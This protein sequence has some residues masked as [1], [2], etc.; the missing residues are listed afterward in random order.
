MKNEAL[1]GR[2]GA[3]SCGDSWNQWVLEGSKCERGESRPTRGHTKLKWKTSKKLVKVKKCLL[4]VCDELGRKDGQAR[5]EFREVICRSK[6]KVMG[7][8]LEV[9]YIDVNTSSRRKI[10]CNSNLRLI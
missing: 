6:A 9:I 1:G 4:R 3:A 8:S 7:P 10:N 2:V 5:G